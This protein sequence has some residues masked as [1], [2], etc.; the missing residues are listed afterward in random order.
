MAQHRIQSPRLA[1][2]LLP[3]AML[4][5][6]LTL[7]AV[8]QHQQ[9]QSHM[10]KLEMQ[11]DHDMGHQDSAGHA[12]DAFGR[13]GDPGAVSRT[14]EIEARDIAFDVTRLSIQPGTTVRFVI[15]N[16]GQI[17]HEFVLGSASEQAEHAK[18]MKN[19]QPGMAH[20]DPNAVIVK[21]GRTA[22]IVW[23]LSDQP[24][25]IEYTCHAPGHYEAGMRGAI[26]PG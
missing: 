21:P 6:P 26:S 16:T 1:F 10:D 4:V 23:Q 20:A 8:E 2:V 5:S 3:V 18:E 24:L 15:R 17:P 25:Q 13:P 7:A 11:Q 14:I 22:E 19:M 12:D 9:G